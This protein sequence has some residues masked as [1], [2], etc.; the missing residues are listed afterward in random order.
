MQYSMSNYSYFISQFTTFLYLPV[1][2][3]IVLFKLLFT[4]HISA[5]S[6]LFPQWKFCVM[7]LFDAL[8]GLL[9]V[10]GGIGVPGMMQNLLLQGA[11]PVTMLFSLFM[12]RNRGDDVSR[13]AR[14]VLIERE[15]QFEEQY[16]GEEEVARA[17][18]SVCRIL[19]NGKD[20]G[21]VP[22]LL[23]HHAPPDEDIIVVA[24]TWIR[25]HLCCCLEKKK[26]RT[27]DLQNVTLFSG[28]SQ[29]ELAGRV[30][31]ITDAHTWS[32]H[33]KTF[34]SVSQ[35]VGAMIIMVGLIVSV[36]PSI[37]GSGNSG[38]IGADLLFFSATIPIAVSGVYKEIGFKSVEDM[39]VWY[40]NGYVAFPQ[41][42][43][44]LLYAPLAAVI[45]DIS[46]S[47]IPSNLWKGY[48]CWALGTNFITREQGYDCSIDK[49]CTNLNGV[50]CC[51]SCDGSIPSISSMPALWGLLLYMTANIAYNVMLVLV[52]KHGSASLMYATSTVVLP[53]GAIAFTL[54]PI[55]QQ[56]AIPFNNY[57]GVGLG[58]ILFGLLIYRFL[59]RFIKK[60]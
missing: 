47:D 44:G 60:K 22:E 35:Y 9:I 53:L 8:Q 37:H 51:D 13:T 20:V 10:V 30:V 4:D 25:E 46:I 59:D 3:A 6:L 33:F 49:D 55:M 50:T 56:H 7:G 18:G 38:T 52:I 41:F 43:L 31:L 36:W 40:L 26:K 21:N 29:D 5:E 57:T 12:L 19:V 48:Q 2:F 11:V 14:E 1:N 27:E 42:V 34:Y 54:K 32:H 58:V 23:R 45:S 15:I 39:D 17:G 28:I 16:A 24:L